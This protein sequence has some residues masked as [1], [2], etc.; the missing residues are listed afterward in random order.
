MKLVLSEYS[1]QPDIK[2]PPKKDV[3]EQ[4]LVQAVVELQLNGISHL[5]T[6]SIELAG[7]KEPSSTAPSPPS[8]PVNGPVDDEIE[9]PLCT[10]KSAHRITFQDVTTA[11]FLIKGGVE[12]TPCPVLANRR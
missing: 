6:N 5:S 4:S 11:S 12:Y 1:D 9:D 10:A 2:M 8:T 7:S 3:K